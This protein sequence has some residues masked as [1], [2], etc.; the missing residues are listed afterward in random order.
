MGSNTLFLP[1]VKTPN[2]KPNFADA[3]GSAKFSNYSQP[4]S[5]FLTQIQA[6]TLVKN[7]VGFALANADA[8]FVNNPTFSTLF[9]QATAAGFDGAFESSSQSNTKVVASFS[10]GAHQ[11]FSFNFSADLRLTSKEIENSN[12]EYSQAKSNIGF[13]VLESENPN[14]AKVKGFFGIAGDL[15]SSRQIGDLDF[16]SSSNVNLNRPFKTTDIDGNNGVDFVKGSARGTYQQTFDRDTKITIVEVNNNA[17]NL[18]ADTLINSLGK[19]VRYGSIWD[20]KLRGTFGNDKIYASLGDD[21]IEGL[22]GDD[23]LEG[24]KGNDKLNGGFGD[25]KLHGS[26]GDDTLVGGG[27]SD[28]MVGGSGAD[29]FVFNRSDSLLGDD[30]DIIKDFQV[31]LDKVKFQGFGQIDSKTWYNNGINQGYLTN[32]SNGALLS[33]AKGGEVLFENVNLNQLK[34]SDVYFA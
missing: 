23:I 31:G 17:V 24:G 10:V 34:H 30:F 14:Q 4:A 32:T 9:S 16:G 3:T 2:S 1:I 7:G 11:Q 22:T 15:I 21:S 25:D 29:T 8:T 12:R 19:D 26:F 27:G 20:D 28:T 18:L 13:L 5:G 33:D 6:Q